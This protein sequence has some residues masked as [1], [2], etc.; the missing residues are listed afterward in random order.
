MRRTKTK[1]LYNYHQH[2]DK[3][4]FDVESDDDNRS[5]TINEELKKQS[6]CPIQKSIIT[7]TIKYLTKYSS[8]S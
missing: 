7:L 5:L 6:Y 8:I 3:D 2:S 1:R 4:Q